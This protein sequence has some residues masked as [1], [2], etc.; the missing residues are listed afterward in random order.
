MRGGMLG[1]GGMPGMPMMPMG[2]APAP[3]MMGPGGA[4]PP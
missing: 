4:P 1:R 2:M 3:M